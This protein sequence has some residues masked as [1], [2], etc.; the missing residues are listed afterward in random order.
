MTHP[1]EV[2][3]LVKFI[4]DRFEYHML[5]ED[6]PEATTSEIYKI[7]KVEDLNDVKDCWRG[8]TSFVCVSPV[9]NPLIEIAG[10][11][12]SRFYLFPAKII[13]TKTAKD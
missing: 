2:G 10:L 12:A 1:S 6:Y 4:P 7:T 3:Q 13:K 5:K 8:I 9:T 11:Y